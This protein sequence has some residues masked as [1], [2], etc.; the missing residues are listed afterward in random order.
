MR[1]YKFGQKWEIGQKPPALTGLRKTDAVNPIKPFNSSRNQRFWKF[2][3]LSLRMPEAGS[4]AIGVALAERPSRW[5]W[6]RSG[7][8]SP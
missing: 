2:W 8:G 1:A 6:G 4:L 7:Q 5:H 3:S